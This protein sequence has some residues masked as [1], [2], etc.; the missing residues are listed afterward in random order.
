M[1]KNAHESIKEPCGGREM[2]SV[3][4]KSGTIPLPSTVKM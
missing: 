3:A 1:R 4:F 2:V